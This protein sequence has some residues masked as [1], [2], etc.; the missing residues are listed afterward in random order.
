MSKVHIALVGGQPMPIHVGIEEFKAEKVILVHSKESKF[1]AEAIERMLELPCSLRLFNPVDYAKIQHDAEMLLN[2]LAQEEVIINISGGTKPWTVA[3]VLLAQQHRNTS[4]IYVDQNNVVYNLTKKES[5]RIGFNLDTA[6]ILRY[7]NYALNSYVNFKDIQEYEF[8]MA[9]QVEQ[10]K[11][12]NRTSFKELTFKSPDVKK[13]PRWRKTLPDGSYA[14]WNAID[15]S[16][17]M[18]L[19][20]KGKLQVHKYTSPHAISML[21]N[22]GWFEVKVAKTLSNWQA[23]K[24]IIVN[25]IFPYS[26]NAPKNEIDIIVNIGDKLLFVECK[27]SIYDLTDLDKFATAAK[28]YGGTGV[29]MLFVTAAKLNDK[30]TEKCQE[31][32]IIPFSFQTGGFIPVDKAL[33]SL[34]NNEMFN[35]NTK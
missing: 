33:F 20:S 22:S 31:N 34:L 28:K 8:Q 17:T 27:T 24:D 30:V 32:H 26:D 35:I 25:A 14:Q 16:A 12:S 2:E 11:K 19:M 7:N 13:E 15:N 1:Q 10:I 6:T 5:K 9:E 18:A 23:A 4:V 21:F 3:F 29:K